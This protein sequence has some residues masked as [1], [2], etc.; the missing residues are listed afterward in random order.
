[1]VEGMIQ[2]TESLSSCLSCN[3]LLPGLSTPDLLSRLANHQTCTC[4]LMSPSLPMLLVRPR[5]PIP[6]LGYL[7]LASLVRSG[8][9]LGTTAS[10]R[11]SP[12]PHRALDLL[13]PCIYP[14]ER[15][16]AAA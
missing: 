4:A 13:Y 12:C 10:P 7:R 5:T 15:R 3:S 14:Y 6:R 2:G 16:H 9:G 8:F 1:M 11:S